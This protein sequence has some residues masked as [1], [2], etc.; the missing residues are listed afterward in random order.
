MIDQTL[1]V[2]PAR[3]GSQ[4][5]RRKNLITGQEEDTSHRVGRWQGGPEPRP[6]DV[7]ESEGRIRALKM[8]ND[9]HRTHQSKGAPSLNLERGVGCG[10]K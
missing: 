4:E 7:R 5:L 8:G 3:G 6:M 9:W 10:P 2:V 1:A